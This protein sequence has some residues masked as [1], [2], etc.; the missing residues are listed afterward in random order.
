MIL[1]NAVNTTE[2]IHAS[3]R[4]AEQHREEGSRLIEIGISVIEL[5]PAFLFS[6]GSVMDS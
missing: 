5:F 6:D 3:Y 2:K 1:E 4:G